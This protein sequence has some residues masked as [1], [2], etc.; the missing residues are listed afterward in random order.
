MGGQVERSI[1]KNPS[2][3][4][5]VTCPQDACRYTFVLFAVSISM[6]ILAASPY[7]YPFFVILSGVEV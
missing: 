6:T 1:V 7:R 2:T 5:R 3:P 4:L